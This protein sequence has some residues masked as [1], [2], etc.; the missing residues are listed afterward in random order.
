MWPRRVAEYLEWRAGCAGG[1]VADLSR[2]RVSVALAL[3]PPF[4]AG[5][6]AFGWRALALAGAACLAAFASDAIAKLMRPEGSRG[7]RWAWL[8]SGLLV[9][10]MMP[11]HAP[12]WL[13]AL[14]G[15]IA[16]FA[17]H[18]LF[19]RKGYCWLPP[20]A[21][22]LLAAP[23]L[24]P[25]LMAS[26][27]WPVLRSYA[28]GTILS[29]EGSDVA[30]AGPR[31]SY[32]EAL[33]RGSIPS[34]P[35][36][37]QLT[38]QAAFRAP[39]GGD[40]GAGTESAGRAF[41][42][43]QVLSGY[44]SGTCGGTSG[45]AWIVAALLLLL[46]GSA[47]WRP[48]AVGAAIFAAGM[49]AASAPPGDIAEWLSQA[50]AHMLTGGFPAALLCW[51]SDPAVAGRTPRAQAAAGAV[52]GL[53]AIAHRTV[54]PPVEDLAFASVVAAA[55]TPLLDRLWPPAPP[56]E[57]PPVATSHDITRP[58][59]EARTVETTPAEGRP[60]RDEPV[61]KEDAGPAP[62]GR[63]SA[64]TESANAKPAGGERDVENRANYE[65][66]NANGDF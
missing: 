14:C 53:L 24:L 5:L 63:G 30:D 55:L 39:A 37:L 43:V 21:A 29:F 20:S 49:L 17:G 34:K 42:L 8:T 10:A 11:P 26:G 64:G 18:V 4:L 28:S 2:G 50:A 41:D 33:A 62:S 16:V 3:V 22:G 60:V 7:W 61:R 66:K 40:P 51:T 45:F 35:A 27:E 15:S 25:S 56:P 46:T 23:F 9:G 52:F 65:T 6:V 58:S 19:G 13:A 54:L 48:A 44:T 36:V 47:L 31:R 38:P 57:T 32:S 12:I 59:V 1:A